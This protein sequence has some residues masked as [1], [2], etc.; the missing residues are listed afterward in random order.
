MCLGCRKRK[1]KEDLVRFTRGT[2]GALVMN[3]KG[4]L[5]GR[6]YYL[7]PET[8]CFRKA[9]KKY[10]LERVFGMDGRPFPTE[11]GFSKKRDEWLR[12]SENGED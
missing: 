6:G 12:R 11:A 10:P 4:F 7:C 1:R 3:E 8:G 2:E 9:H 5:K